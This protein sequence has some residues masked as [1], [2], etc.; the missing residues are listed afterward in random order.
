MAFS[1]KIINDNLKDTLDIFSHLEE[2]SVK[3]KLLSQVVR[4]ELMNLRSGNAHTKTRAEVRGGGRKP[5]KQKGTGKA[6]HGSIRS[7]L[8]VGGGVAFGPRNTVNWHCKINK[9]SRIAALKSILKDRL[10]DNKIYTFEENFNFPKTKEAI[11]IVEKLAS[12]AATNI[13]NLLIIYTTAEKDKLNGFPNTEVKMINA[14][15]LQIHKL[16][17]ANSYLITPSA[18][19]ILEKRTI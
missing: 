1:S 2:Y 18:L 13:K 9:S 12:D 3:E 17:G 11:K 10:I 15:Q 16:V 4:S 6:R 19:E 14:Q 5:W 7:P 8:W